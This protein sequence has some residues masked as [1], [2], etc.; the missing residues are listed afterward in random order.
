[1]ADIHSAWWGHPFGLLMSAYNWLLNIFKIT[2]IYLSP[3][4]HLSV[5]WCWF[6]CLKCLPYPFS[7]FITNQTSTHSSKPSP[8]IIFL[9]KTSPHHH[10]QFLP[11]SNFW[12]KFLLPPLCYIWHNTFGSAIRLEIELCFILLFSPCISRYLVKGCEIIDL[13]TMELQVLDWLCLVFSLSLWF[14][15]IDIYIT[16]SLPEVSMFFQASPVLSVRSGGRDDNDTKGNQE[17][18]DVM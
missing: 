16:V 11:F 1:M 9:V 8:N 7:P 18:R 5:C 4:S 6:L 17:A 13:T 15:E 2:S 3:V 10:H 12:K 14:P